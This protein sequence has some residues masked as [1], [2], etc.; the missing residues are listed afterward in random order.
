VILGREIATNST[1]SEES[2][3]CAVPRGRPKKLLVSTKSEQKLRDTLPS[4]AEIVGRK[5]RKKFGR[6]GYFTGKVTSYVYPYYHI[7]YDKDGDHED[8]T[9]SEVMRLLIPL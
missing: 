1:T 9:R 5:I 6:L 3:R 7:N 8:L 2:A 4:D